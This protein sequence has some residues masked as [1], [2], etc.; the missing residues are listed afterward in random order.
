MRKPINRRRP[1]HEVAHTP[2]F[3]FPA[4]RDYPAP[5]RRHR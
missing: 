5:R 2:R 3:P 4:L 1:A